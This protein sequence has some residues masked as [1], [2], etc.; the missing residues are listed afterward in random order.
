ML[1]DE[2]KRSTYDKYGKAG[3]QQ[4]EGG[5]TDPIDMMKAMFGGDSFADTFGDLNMWETIKIQLMLSQGAQLTEEMIME[6]LQT[7]ALE[8]HQKLVKALIMKLEPFVTNDLAKFKAFMETDVGEKAAAPGGVSLLGAIG[9]IYCQTSQQFMDRFLGLGNV[10]AKIGEKGHKLKNN[11]SALSAAVKLTWSAVKLQ[12]KM[13]DEERQKV[14]KWMKEHPGVPPPGACT[15]ETYPF[16]LDERWLQY[17]RNVEIPEGTD[18]EKVAALDKVRRKWY[19]NTIGIHHEAWIEEETA[20]QASLEGQDPMASEQGQDMKKVMD[21]G[22]KLMWKL[23]VMEAE[24]I[25]REVV[26]EICSPKSEWNT[27]NK[28]SKDELKRRTLGIHHIGEKYKAVAEKL[29]K[30][31]KKAGFSMDEFLKAETAGG[32]PGD[33]SPRRPRPGDVEN[34]NNAPKDATKTDT[35]PVAPPVVDETDHAPKVKSDDVGKKW[36]LL[37]SFFLSFFFFL[38]FFSLSFFLVRPLFSHSKSLCR[39]T[40]CFL[41]VDNAR[42]G[43]TEKGDRKRHQ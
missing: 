12:Q 16:E 18:E 5:G 25:V 4:A 11:M 2:G 30:A 15:Y 41:F 8:R 7:F 24:E 19:H 22:L 28:T 38:F 6:R 31:E 26:R 29:S 3:V 34:N 23:G 14:E 10:F 37:S 21:Q 33:K 20:R 9:Y 36:F 17:Q 1:S 32:A 43:K 13:E 27:T 35:D 42:D 39:L 40:C